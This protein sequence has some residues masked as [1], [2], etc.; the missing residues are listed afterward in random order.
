MNEKDFANLKPTVYIGKGGL[1]ENI[2]AE[3]K[4]QIK[5]NGVIKI[6]ILRSAESSSFM[7]KKMFAEKIAEKSNTD[8]LDI[9]GNVIVIRKK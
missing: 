6:R 4:D 7:D 2:I 3:I 5:K 9:R 1:T 8:I